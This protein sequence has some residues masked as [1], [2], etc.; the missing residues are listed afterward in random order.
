[1]GG[2]LGGT[3]ASTFGERW[4]SSRGDV[5]D[6]E[7]PEGPQKVI[8]RPGRRPLARLPQWGRFVLGPCSPFLGT[9]S[10]L[11]LRHGLGPVRPPGV[12]ADRSVPT[13]TRPHTW[14]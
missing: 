6:K 5:A 14:C 2:P 1:M 8:S 3:P 9:A 10:Q 7:H 11:R 13:A 12:S 4:V